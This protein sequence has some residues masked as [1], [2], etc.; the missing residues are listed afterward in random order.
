MQAFNFVLI[1]YKN[2]YINKYSY[3]TKWIMFGDETSLL[4]ISFI[5]I[6]D[7]VSIIILFTVFLLSQNVDYALVLFV[8]NSIIV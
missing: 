2:N 5:D 7:D 8:S 1:Q 3:I 4:I 6:H